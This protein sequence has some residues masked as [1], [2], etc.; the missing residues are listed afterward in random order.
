MLK[1]VVRLSL[2]PLLA[3]SYS[4]L[5]FGP[6]VTLSMLVVVLMTPIFL[7]S[8]CRRKAPGV[9]SWLRNK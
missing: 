2:L 5:Y 6:I 7:V 9:Q 3:V 8:F 4:T 1:G